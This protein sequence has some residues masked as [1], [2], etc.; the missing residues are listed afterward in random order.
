MNSTLIVEP[1]VSSVTRLM[2]SVRE[3]P[4]T[5]QG[6]SLICSPLAALLGVA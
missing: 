2:S 5:P 1:A 4:V 6:L 3:S